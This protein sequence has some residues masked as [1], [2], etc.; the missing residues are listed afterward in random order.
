MYIF[1]TNCDRKT[2][3]ME[4]SNASYRWTKICSLLLST[5]CC[6]TQNADWLFLKNNVD[7]I[8]P[9]NVSDK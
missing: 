4:K 3:L 2:Q 8:V 9:P 5:A 7:R 6:V 1:S